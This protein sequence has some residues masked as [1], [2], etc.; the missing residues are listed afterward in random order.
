MSPHRA[1]VVPRLLVTVAHPDDETFGCGS[2]LALASDRGVETVVACATR[3]EAGTPTPGSGV[4]VADLGRV[5]EEELR[6]AAAYLGVG[7]VVLFDWRD[8]GMDG[9]PER[10][11]FVGAPLE[12]VAAAV[13][14]LIDDVHPTIVV[15]LDASD[16]HRD[17]AHI[18]DATLLAV[19]QAS[20]QVPRVYFQCL[21]RA[22]MGR[23]ADELRV[24]QPDAG[25]LAIAE[26]GTPDDLVTTVV[27]TSAQL[28]RREH[29]MRL[30]ATQTSPYEVMP[31]DLRRAFLA[32]D[33]F[34]RVVPP[35]P[36]GLPET[37]LF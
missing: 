20:W 22:L 31:A 37:D 35:W 23:W 25:H 19:E 28:E 21:S 1:E 6:Q 27:D 33:R 2:L 18:R 16:G 32:T 5:R 7:R 4:D 24:K 11:A 13:A 29:A 17:H 10:D 8:S 12:S 36:G 34:R 9:P 15:T 30:H 3:G 14:D 26:L